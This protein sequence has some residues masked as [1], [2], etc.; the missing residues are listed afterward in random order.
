MAIFVTSREFDLIQ[1]KVCFEHLCKKGATIELTEKKPKR[2]IQQNK[3]LYF[4]LGYF[5]LNYG[6]TTQYVKEYFFKET[7]N[8]EIFKYKR[9][10]QKTGE[11][12]IALRSSADLD[13]RELTIAIDR[14]RD[15]SS[16][17]FGLY[18]PLPHENQ[19]L[20]Q[21]EKELSMYSN[22]LYL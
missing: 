14:F 16:K 19:Y 18:L 15:Y 21:I 22:Q 8:P 6:E 11:V 20:E 17:E 12:R 10:N 5:A 2:S 7:V 1:S 3:Y 9:V 13:S 4:L